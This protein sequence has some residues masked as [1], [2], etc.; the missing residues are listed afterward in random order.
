[1]LLLHLCEHSCSMLYRAWRLHMPNARLLEDH[2]LLLKS[3]ASVIWSNTAPK[4]KHLPVTLPSPLSGALPSPLSGA[5]PSPLSGTLPSPLSVILSSSLSV[6]LL[7]P[8]QRWTGFL[9]KATKEGETQRLF[10]WV[11]N[12]WKILVSLNCMEKTVNLNLAV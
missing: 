10:R 7:Y 8:L 11:A 12:W 2:F 5:L 3:G 1:M 6:N 9:R 4:L